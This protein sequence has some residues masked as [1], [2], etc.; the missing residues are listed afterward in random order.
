[1]SKHAQSNRVSVWW[2]PNQSSSD[3][4]LQWDTHIV[5]F[6]LFAKRVCLPPIGQKFL[7]AISF[8]QFL[9]LILKRWTSNLTLP[10]ACRSSSF[11]HGQI[12]YLFK[13]H[14]RVKDIMN[15]T[16]RQVSFQLLFRPVASRRIL[17]HDI[18][19]RAPARFITCHFLPSHNSI[20]LTRQTRHSRPVTQS[21]PYPFSSLADKRQ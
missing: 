1:M 13:T 18:S 5:L 10:E 11:H 2:R 12:Q 17:A 15:F 8:S 3:G 20:R 16:Y 19:R 4:P 6:L 7:N 21:H 9:F 14:Y